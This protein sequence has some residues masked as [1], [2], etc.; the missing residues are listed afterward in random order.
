[1]FVGRKWSVYLNQLRDDTTEPTIRI[2][3]PLI[4]IRIEHLKIATNETTQQTCINICS[5]DMHTFISF[6]IHTLSFTHTQNTL[7]LCVSNGI[8]S[9]CPKIPS[10]FNMNVHSI[11]IYFPVYHNTNLK[12]NASFAHFTFSHSRWILTLSVISS[13]SVYQMVVSCV[14]ALSGRW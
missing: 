8:E 4:F 10:C 1:M 13:H 14:F 6:Y 3:F 7:H 5:H 11:I 12:Q 9:F 2:L